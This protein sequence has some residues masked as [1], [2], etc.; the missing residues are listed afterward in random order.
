MSGPDSADLVFLG[1]SVNTMTDGAARADAVAVRG[2]RIVHV[3]S[4]AGARELIGRRTRTVELRGETLL[5]GFQDAHVHPIDGGMMANVCDLHDVDE[6]PRAYLDAIAAYAAAHPERDWITGGG[7][8]LPAFPRGEPGRG[9]LDAVVPDRPAFLYS[10][11]GHVGWANSRALAIAGIDRSTPDPPGGRIVRDET[12]EPS[13]TL[14]DYAIDI[15]MP[16]VPQ[17]THEDMLDGLRAAQ[18]HL[19]KLGITAWQDAHVEPDA[20]AA[21]R[22]AA[23]AGWLTARVVAALWWDRDAGLEQIESFEAQRAGSAIGRL[24]ADSVKLMLDGILESRTALMLSPYAGT[25]GGMGSPFID[26]ELLR[27]AVIELDRRGFQAHFHAIGDGAIR[28]ALDAVEAA[29]AANG[30]ADHRHHIAHLEV[31]H[32]DDVPRFGRLGVVANLQPFWASDDDQMQAL[33]IPVLGPE[34]TGWQF[35]FA[36]LL[37]TGATLAG[38]SDWTVSTPNPLLEIEVAVTRVAPDR[39]DAAPFLPGERLTLDAALRAFT[40]GSAYVNHLDAETGTVE[41]G[42]LADLV[43]LDRD[44]RAPDAGP[45]GEASV[46]HTFVAGEEVYR[47]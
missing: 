47:A 13:G 18:R 1:A 29:R 19:H 32:P 36:S 6:T 2:G 35:P 42:K 25:D 21:Y 4:S 15:L 37:R 38:G 31:V 7:W 9:K 3:G 12:G 14:H 39:R 27:E 20:L 24:R 16:H 10:D 26:P 5:P 46:R 40:A 45:I 17:P 28:L 11:D 44:L 30:G 43:V 8:S 34:R 22:E 41:V 23:A 33:R